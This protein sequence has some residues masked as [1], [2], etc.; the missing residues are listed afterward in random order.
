MI[1]VDEKALEC[2]LETLHKMA[3]GRVSCKSVQRKAFEC[4]I[5]VQKLHPEFT[6]N[7]V[8]KSSLESVIEKEETPCKQ[9]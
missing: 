1:M 5:E 8:L 7:E 6:K 3:R 4:L 2:M 9:K